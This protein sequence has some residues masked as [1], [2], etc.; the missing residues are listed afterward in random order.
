[1]SVSVNT[2]VILGYKFEIDDLPYEEC[3]PYLDS[4][5]EGIKHHKGLFVLYDGMNGGYSIIGRVL[6]KTQ[7]NMY[8]EDPFTV[9]A[10][11]TQKELIAG[12]INTLLKPF[13][14]IKPDE[15]KLWVVSHHR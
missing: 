15:I 1:M 4:C 12:Y 10:D 9:E 6:A 11:L 7:N 5:H 13:E 2:Y 8:F 14:D 3:E